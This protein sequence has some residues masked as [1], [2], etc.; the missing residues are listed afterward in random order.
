MRARTVAV[1]ALLSAC[2]SVRAQADGVD[3]P[4]FLGRNDMVWPQLPDSWDRAPFVG[5]GRLGTIFWQ[6]KGGE[7]Y[8]E[9]SR[10]DLYDHRRMSKGYAELFATER[11][12][13]G[14][15]TLTFD[16]AQAK[17]TG[18]MRLDLWNAEAR[19]L[20]KVEGKGAWQVSC[21]A[22]ATQDVIVLNV[23]RAS[24]S[25]TDLRPSLAWV[26]AVAGS[27]RDRGVPPD[28][29]PY[30]PPEEREVDGVHVS[31]QEMPEDKRYHTDGLGAGQ[32]ATAW[33]VV[34]EGQP[35]QTILI[36]TKIS[37]PGRTAADEAA[38]A[39]KAAEADAGLEASHCAWWHDYYRKSFLS[40]PD[41]AVE[42]FYWAQM[43]KMGSASRQGGPVLDLMGP[44]FMRTGW[45]AI[46]W[47]LNIQLAYWP[48]YMSNHVEEAEP[49]AETV[50]GGRARLAE[51]AAPYQADSYAIGRASGPGCESPVGAEVGNLPWVMQNLWMQYRSTMDDAFLRERLFPLMKGS[52]NYLKH[53]AAKGSDGTLRLKGVASPE[54]TDKV[55]DSSYALA[56]LRW[57][58]TTIIAADAR[59]KANDP[60][61]GDCRDVLAHLAPYPVDERTGVMVGDGVT[62][63]H[64]H[65]H[66]SHLFMIYP[67]HEWSWD[68]A[69]RRPL[70]ERSLEN[71]TSQPKAFA[72][73]S[74]LG[75]A[76]M[77]EGRGNGDRG[78]E[79]VRTFLGRSPLPNTLYREGSPVIE[80]PL[81]CAR[82]LQEMVLQSD[83]DRIRVFPAVPGAW[84]DVSFAN[85][86]AEGA[87]LVSAERRGGMTTYVK[88]KSLAGEP[89]RL[90][91]DLPA[92]T[93]LD[94]GRARP[95]GDGSYELKLARGE[96]M[97]LG[98]GSGVSAVERTG[99]FQP[100]GMRRGAEAP[101]EVPSGGATTRGSK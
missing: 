64:S 72:G 25:A 38:A 80:T 49:L 15:F 90:Q 9:V 5:N 101:A 70:M 59:L 78:L 50:W 36:S 82:T 69:E 58:A 77:W 20:V 35:W 54:Y 21:Y 6:R 40:V 56:C 1:A 8:F 61:V 27:T 95:L 96:E 53:I 51:N 32:V 22:H 29:L 11:L 4:G 34:R 93:R 74:W 42:S 37:Y 85:F 16:G 75:A 63:A 94:S 31:V 30:P 44:W 48:F 13:R 7:L 65:R 84:K 57:L 92:G 24:H 87:F 73:Y 99:D 39:V 71:W 89:C 26:P 23:N 68:D 60:I 33:K 83:G 19:G 79:Y 45:P 2:A 3:W 88:V 41:G 28:Y 43:Y 91:V 46:W 97:T 76:A 12:P 47:N 86:R 14:G 17:P 55:D 52:F 66:W 98:E 100:W 67:F 18:E 62:F 81:A 10:G